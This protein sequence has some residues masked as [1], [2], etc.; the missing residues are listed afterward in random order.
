MNR[1]VPQKRT[2]DGK[3]RQNLSCSVKTVFF[4]L[5]IRWT[6]GA[7]HRLTL[8]CRG[9]TRIDV[10]WM[11]EINGQLLKPEKPYS[12]MFQHVLVELR[13]RK[14]E[15]KWDGKFAFYWP[16]SGNRITA[17]GDR[18]I[19]FIEKVLSPHPSCPLTFP[20]AMTERPGKKR[21][22]L[23]IE[24]RGFRFR[25]DLES[26]SASDFAIKAAQALSSLFF[27]GDFRT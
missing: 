18:R 5:F 4:F 25:G 6:T 9:I 16:R 1:T 27:I 22:C 14:G 11:L 26:V 17:K 12:C 23:F 24:T 2:E 15:G 20:R 21:D 10:L 8:Q 19:E 7:A 3:A 13:F